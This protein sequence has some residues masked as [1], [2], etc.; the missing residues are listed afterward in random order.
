MR[1]EFAHAANTARTQKTDAL[2]SAFRCAYWLAKEGLPLAKYSSLL[3]FCK[4]QGCTAISNLESGKNATYQSWQSAED[5]LQSIVEVIVSDIDKQLKD[6]QFVSILID[7][8]TDI[9]VTKKMVIYGRTVTND[10]QQKTFF[11]GNVAF[12]EPHVN[13]TLI[14]T[15]LKAFLVNRGV[16]VDK[17]FGFGSDGASIMTGSK[18]GVATQFKSD[19]PHCV[20][21]HCFAHKLALCTE[22]AAD[23]VE[24]ISKTFNKTLT[25][26]HYYFKKSSCR[27]GTL[28]QLQQIM[29]TKCVRIKEVHEIRWFAFYDALQAL[30]KSWK[31]LVRYFKDLKKPSEK[32]TNLLTSL[33]D[34]R[35]IST[36]HLMMD[37]LPSYT[38]LSMLF[39]KQDLDIAVVS[40]ALDGAISSAKQARDGKGYYHSVLKDNL[41]THNDSLLYKGE[42]V[43][44]KKVKED[45][46][47][48][49]QIRKSFVDALIANTNKRFPKE[50]TDIVFAF[51]SM[52]MRGISFMSA[53]ALSEYGNG[54]L[55]KLSEFYGSDQKIKDVVSKAI[56]NTQ[57]CLREWALVKK[58]VIEQRYPTDNSQML[59]SI[60]CKYH[61]EAF[62]NLITLAKLLLVIPLQTADCERGFS[63]QNRIHTALRNKLKP[64]KVEQ[65]MT[66]M[67]EGPSVDTFAYQQ[68]VNIWS[69]KQ[70]R[71]I[72]KKC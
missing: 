54:D 51:K 41:S 64:S 16:G 69:S 25:N 30:Y 45:R 12:E 4:L 29:E 19:N 59:W 56:V 48:F 38:Q 11:L 27:V 60:L 2:I 35:F 49:S 9:S 36:M 46:S 68:A 13:A 63:C 1:K 5:I 20:N 23:S 22:K 53:D 67:L 15:R 70:Q 7:E 6:S 39:Q 31:P 55:H 14:Y 3:D 47:E 72:F 17:V 34:I 57:A 10:C 33:T 21:V 50:S 52:G 71:R 24:Y 18:T 62:P 65:L 28:T 42:K 8:T 44:N 43:S 66:V 26:L 58:L 61:G 37:I 32:E 40:P